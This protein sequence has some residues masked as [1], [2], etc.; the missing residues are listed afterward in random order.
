MVPWRLKYLSESVEILS[1]EMREDYIL[2][3]KKAIGE[4]KE[5]SNAFLLKLLVRNLC[6]FYGSVG[7]VDCASVC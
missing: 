6:F 7:R 1:D 5:C 2:S 4:K 3:V